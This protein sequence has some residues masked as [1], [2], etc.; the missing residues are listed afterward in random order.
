[1][2]LTLNKENDFDPAKTAVSVFKT[3]IP[4]PIDA[5]QYSFDNRPVYIFYAEEDDN[6]GSM[7]KLRDIKELIERELNFPIDER[8]IIMVQSIRK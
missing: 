2:R 1:M 3:N 5:S 7:I 4:L 8:D 6:P